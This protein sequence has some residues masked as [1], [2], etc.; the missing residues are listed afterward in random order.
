MYIQPALELPLPPNWQSLDHVKDSS[1][2][3]L[4][5]DALDEA[6]LHI[7]EAKSHIDAASAL[8]TSWERELALANPDLTGP[9]EKLRDFA[10]LIRLNCYENYHI[11][12]DR[13]E[14]ACQAV[15]RG[16]LNP[17]DP[18]VQ[19]LDVAG[20]AV[21][22][23]FDSRVQV[24]DQ[25][26]KKLDQGWQEAVVTSQRLTLSQVH[27]STAVES[28][29]RA[30]Q[31]ES[32]ALEEYKR[33]NLE[34]RMKEW[35]EARNRYQEKYGEMVERVEKTPQWNPW[36]ASLGV[37][38]FVIT[39]GKFFF[40]SKAFHEQQQADRETLHRLS[41]TA[42]ACYRDAKDRILKVEAYKSHL[43][44]LHDTN[45]ELGRLLA[46]LK[47]HQGRTRVASQRFVSLR[48]YWR[49]LWT[50]VGCLEGVS[51]QL[52]GH[53]FIP[54]RAEV[55]KTVLQVVNQATV[56]QKAAGV[57][58]ILQDTLYLLDTAN[59]WEQQEAGGVRQMITSLMKLV[60]DI[61]HAVQSGQVIPL[62]IGVGGSGLD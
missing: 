44:A 38:G 47:E 59:E 21:V 16:G 27:L 19:T 62:V 37:Y 13:Y 46:S 28:T 33:T 24:L 53:G 23:A 34:P 43:Q 12:D 3:E 5:R 39:T 52:G 32:A 35:E 56:L 14:A 29:E 20:A 30:E 11:A 51:R 40:D 55:V 9:L 50:Q 54:S 26:G 41:Q 22:A 7:E 36:T 2:M 31:E 49:G 57:T 6:H 25:L 61:D 48:A 17:Q 18:T 42:D 58:H 10:A 4:P 15:L 60:A 8:E 1:S 45:A